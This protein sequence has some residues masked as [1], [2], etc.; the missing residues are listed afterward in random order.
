MK[1]QYQG[2]SKQQPCGFRECKVKSQQQINLKKSLAPSNKEDTKSNK[3]EMGFDRKLP[4][5]A[6]KWKCRNSEEYSACS[7]KE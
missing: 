7:H 1:R 4:L 2:Q 5:P 6:W 3:I